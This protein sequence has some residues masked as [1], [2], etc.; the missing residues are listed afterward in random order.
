MKEIA[1]ESILSK[2]EPLKSG[3]LKNVIFKELF[4]EPQK[5]ITRKHEQKVQESPVG[6]IKAIQ[7]GPKI[8]RT[9][10]SKE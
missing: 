6:E 5:L 8:Y 3:L 2:K 4:W 7:P 9:F 10:L 1:D